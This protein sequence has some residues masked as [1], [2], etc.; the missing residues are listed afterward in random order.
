MKRTKSK[1]ITDLK[2]V[3]K[4][5]RKWAGQAHREA[6]EEKQA[7]AKARKQGYTELA[8]ELTWDSKKADLWR[9]M[10][11]KRATIAE[12]KAQK[13]KRKK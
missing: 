8:K 1:K 5:E 10:R 12:R 11:L 9:K 3:S 2:K 7:A 6:I 13:I 4:I